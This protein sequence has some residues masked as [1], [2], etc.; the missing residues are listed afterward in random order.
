MTKEQLENQYE[1]YEALKGWNSHLFQH[2]TQEANLFKKE[3]ENISIV[4]KK[5]LDIGF[6]Q[7]SLLDW[8]KKNNAVVSGVEIQDN[9]IKKANSLGIKT[10]SNI[11]E[12]PSDSFEV[13]A[14]F[15]LIEHIHKKDIQ[16]FLFEIHRIAKKDAI[17]ILRFPNCQSPAGLANQFGD[18]THVNMLSGPLVTYLMEYAGFR[19][20]TYKASIIQEPS[21]FIIRVIKK[22]LIPLSL[23]FEFTYR[24]TWSIKNAPLTPNVTLIAKK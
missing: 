3:F 4:D 12:I 23:L 5:F 16:N 17:I 9:L 13:I 14:A 8:A 7:G 11:E 19:N 18:H 6:G 22:S 21:S 24:I 10:Y 20:V 15:D 2:S 1:N